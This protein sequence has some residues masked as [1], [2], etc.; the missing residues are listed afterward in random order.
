M[1]VLRKSKGSQATAIINLD[2]K[3]EKNILQ[4]LRDI[5]GIQNLKLVKPLV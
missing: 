1:E 5:P 2:Q 4:L 3:V